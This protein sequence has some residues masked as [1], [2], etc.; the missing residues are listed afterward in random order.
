MLTILPGV[1][2]TL[3]KMLSDRLSAMSFK[4][5]RPWLEAGLSIH[6]FLAHFICGFA[7]QT[8]SLY[9]FKSHHRSNHNQMLS[10]PY[11]RA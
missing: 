7:F 11:K 8:A 1:V 3:F 6:Q 4:V 9:I 10:N 2:N 5:T